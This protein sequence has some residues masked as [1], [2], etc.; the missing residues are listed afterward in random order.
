MGETGGEHGG[1]ALWSNTQ[2]YSDWAQEVCTDAVALLETHLSS[3]PYHMPDSGSNY[4][5][6]DKIT[7]ADIVIYPFVVNCARFGVNREEVGKSAPQIMRIWEFLKGLEKDRQG[8]LGA[9]LW[10]AR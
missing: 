6:F 7:L 5:F 2:T 3:S 10:S 9:A 4:C 1:N 8:V